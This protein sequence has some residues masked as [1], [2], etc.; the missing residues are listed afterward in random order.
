[1]SLC[2]TCNVLFSTDSTQE[3][4]RHDWKFLDWYVNY[5]LKSSRST[6]AQCKCVRPVIKGLLF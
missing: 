2:K 5:Q 4:S 1:M 3:T 6:V